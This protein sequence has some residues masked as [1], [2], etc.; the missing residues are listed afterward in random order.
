MQGRGLGAGVD[1]TTRARRKERARVGLCIAVAGDWRVELITL[2][3]AAGA[4]IDGA[5]V[6]L[7]QARR[8]R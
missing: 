8:P 2:D 1:E 3:G 4:G 6:F 5:A 7:I